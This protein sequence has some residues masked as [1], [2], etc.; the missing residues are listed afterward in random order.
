MAR[1]TL[2][3]SGDSNKSNL[4][5]RP[6]S[7]NIRGSHTTSIGHFSED[8]INKRKYEIEKSYPNEEDVKNI[9][10]VIFYLFYESFF[11]FR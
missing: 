6:S 1:T 8:R 2:M 3:T 7:G 5:D 10:M 11:L 4:D 9:L